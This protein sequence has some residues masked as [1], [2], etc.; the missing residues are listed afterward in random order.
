M[1]TRQRRESRQ[2][3]FILIITVLIIVMSLNAEFALAQISDISYTL[4]PV[5]E[6]V[7]FDDDAA[8]DNALLFGGKVGFGFGEFIELSGIYLFGS[9]LKTDF[10]NLSGFDAPASALLAD[11]ASRDLELHRYGGELKFN[12][13]RGPVLPFLTFGTGILR[14]DPD[15]LNRSRSIYLSGGIGLKYSVAHR[16]TWYVQASNVAYR[17]NPSSTLLSGDEI[18]SLGLAPDDFS[19]IDVNNWSASVGMQLYLGGRIPGSQTELDRAL[20]NQLAGGWRGIGFRIEP[21]AGEIKFDEM[22]GYRHHQRMIGASAG[23]DLGPY[24]GLRGFYWR[25]TKDGSWSDVDDIHAYGGEL[26]LAF[27]YIGGNLTPYVSLGGGYLNISDD[28]AGN[29]TAIADDRPFA[30]GGIG[31]ILPLGNSLSIDVGVRSLLMTTHGTDNLSD[32]GDVQASTMLSA[33]ISFGVGGSRRSAGAIFGREIEASRADRDRLGADLIK[34]D[35]ALALT[36]ARIDSLNAAVAEQRR[37]LTLQEKTLADQK[38]AIPG[39]AAAAVPAAPAENIASPEA[40]A[41]RESAVSASET[42]APVPAA[43]PAPAPEAAKPKEAR[44]VTLPVPDEG[45]LYLRYG[46]PGTVSIESVSGETPIYYLDAATGA[47][48]PASPLASSPVQA[49]PAGPAAVSG[50]PSAAATV[51]PGMSAQQIDEL[52]R[53][54]VDAEMARRAS[55]ASARDSVA[56]SNIE[57]MLD[58]RLREIESNLDNMS[59]E[60]SKPQTVIQQPASEPVVVREAAP[61]PVVI[62]RQPQAGAAVVAK[63]K[64]PSTRFTAIQPLTGYN[65]DEP[66]QGLLGL[67]VEFQKSGRPYRLWP[68]IILGFG[69]D[70]TTYNVNLNAA[71]MSGFGFADRAYPYGGLG[72]GFLDRDDLELVLNMFVGSEIRLDDATF[73][74]EYVNQDLFDNNRLLAGYRLEF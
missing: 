41:P 64:G 13:G 1:N 14:F 60:L 31:A 40:A 74:I 5:V 55:A 32:P 6:G 73:F 30:I 56:V 68:E 18:A 45:E 43:E 9:T 63:A 19:A 11:L 58:L 37:Q 17:Y 72:L 8:L 12:L 54:G 34:K 52:I 2:H 24:A 44:W 69:D 29:G 20:E 67:R 48:T 28:Y 23:I 39:M 62:T 70:Q 49:A 21:T 10:S 66:K 57:R 50:M 53:R 36:N 22:L 46:K 38:N 25:G 35:A 33:G 15:G 7:K 51:Q 27:S 59:R 47:L 26:K 71:Y 61:A 65:F 42:P 3:G 16:Y 4:T